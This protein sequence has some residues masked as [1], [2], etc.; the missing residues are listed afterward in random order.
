MKMGLFGK[1]KSAFTEDY[2]E[3]SKLY[4]HNPKNKHHKAY[5]VA[6]NK[7]KKEGKSTFE[8]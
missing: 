2:W 4:A 5:N 6:K 3:T 8:F 1:I 7:A